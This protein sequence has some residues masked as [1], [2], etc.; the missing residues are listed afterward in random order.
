MRPRSSHLVPS[1]IPSCVLHAFPE[2]LQAG[3]R[4][5]S[6]LGYLNSVRVAKVSPEKALKCDALYKA[7][8][9]E[10]SS[11][12]ENRDSTQCRRSFHASLPSG[13]G[14][15]ACWYKIPSL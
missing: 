2:K 12:P 4:A 15:I 7:P 14:E 8:D 3:E 9:Q 5:D 11:L 10:I 1:D 6:S 13:L